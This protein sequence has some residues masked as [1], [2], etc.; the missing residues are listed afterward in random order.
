MF[1]STFRALLSTGGTEGKGESIRKG[2][3]DHP[4]PKYPSEGT[5]LPHMDL[6]LRDQLPRGHGA[7]ILNVSP[8]LV[9]MNSHTRLGPPFSAL[10]HSNH[11]H[12]ATLVCFPLLY[13]SA[14]LPSTFS[15]SITLWS[16]LDS[17]T[18]SPFRSQSAP[19]LGQS[20]LCSFPFPSCYFTRCS[21][22][23][24]PDFWQTSQTQFK[25]QAP[26]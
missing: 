14:R 19:R 2:E 3:K 26:E 17:T 13:R 5:P 23:S 10:G 22:F 25:G 18:S 1:H 6:P 20:P 8:W 24:I 4:F 7:L 9:S 16:W 11:L 21:G 12:L 15:N